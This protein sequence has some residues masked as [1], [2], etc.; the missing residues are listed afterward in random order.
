[1]KKEE[2]IKEFKKNAG[3]ANLKDSREILEILGKIIVD[4]MKDPDGITP[5]AGMKFISVYKD[6]MTVKSPSTG[7]PI[8]VSARY[9]PKVRFGKAVK[10]ALN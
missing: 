8:D 10:D 6:A 9:V 5:F 3:L 1:M 2:L 7:E 4:H